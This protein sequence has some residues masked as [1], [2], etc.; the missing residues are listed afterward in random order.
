ME[1]GLYIIKIYL[2]KASQFDSILTS[3]FDLNIS[4]EN[5]QNTTTDITKFVQLYHSKIDD[6]L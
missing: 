1:L 2:C 4:S 6:I 5:N 3:S